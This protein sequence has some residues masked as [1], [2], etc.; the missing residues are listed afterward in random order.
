MSDAYWRS[1]QGYEEYQINCKVLATYLAKRSGEEG[2]LKS[3]SPKLR[4]KDEDHLR[5][6]AEEALEE[7]MD[8]VGIDPPTF[9]ESLVERNK[10]TWAYLLQRV[11]SFNGTW[12]GILEIFS[13]F[14]GKKLTFSCSCD[15]LYVYVWNL[16]EV[17]K[18]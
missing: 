1:K 15:F 3:L 6:E 14:K 2:I 12:C 13:P 16:E 7:I 5:R 17:I 8:S 10:K 4:E 9:L 18:I 11:N